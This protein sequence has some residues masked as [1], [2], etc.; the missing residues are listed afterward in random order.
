MA[1]SIATPPKS[2]VA[3]SPPSSGRSRREESP[4]PPPA[5]PKKGQELEQTGVSPTQAGWMEAILQYNIDIKP[6]EDWE[7]L[8]E[9]LAK[10][11]EKTQSNRRNLAC[12]KALSKF[13]DRQSPRPVTP[14]SGLEKAKLFT[15]IV[16]TQ[17]RKG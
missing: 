5:K 17:C 13:F 8:E 9:K 16:R 3:Q 6:G 12:V 14:K 1:S 4:S 2:R 7:Q 10:V 15:N 11:F